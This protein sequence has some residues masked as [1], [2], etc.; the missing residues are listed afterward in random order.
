MKS[1]RNTTLTSN[2][3]RDLLLVGIAMFVMFLC[4]RAGNIYQRY[5]DAQNAGVKLSIECYKQLFSK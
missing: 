1:K 3:I 5:Q 2:V 4:F